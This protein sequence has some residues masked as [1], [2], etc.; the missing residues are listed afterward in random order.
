[1]RIVVTGRGRAELRPFD[2]PLAA[3]GEVTVEVLASAVSPGTERAQWL[4]LPNAQPAFPYTPGYS[5]PAQVIACRADAGLTEGQSVAVPGCR[6]VHRPLC[7]PPGSLRSR[8][9]SRIAEAALVYLAIIAGYGVRRAGL[10][11][12]TRCV[13]SA[14]VRSGRWRS[15]SRCSADRGA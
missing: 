3:A 14:R 15:G 12:A 9:G 6:T 8:M 13:W 5:G 2:R 7:R 11:P 1:M 10:R 4:R